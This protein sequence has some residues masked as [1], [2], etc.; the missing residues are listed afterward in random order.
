MGSRARCA[1]APVAGG[2]VAV[3]DG[4]TAQKVDA[5][6][7]TKHTPRKKRVPDAPIVRVS[8]FRSAR[9]CSTRDDCLHAVC[10]ELSDNPPGCPPARPAGPDRLGVPETGFP[11]NPGASEHLC[12]RT[13]RNRRPHAACGGR[14]RTKAASR[15]ANPGSG[16]ASQRNPGAPTETRSA[17]GTDAAGGTARPMAGSPWSPEKQIP[18]TERD[19]PIGGG[20]ADVTFLEAVMGNYR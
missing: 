16:G 6:R 2:G 20:H 15:R 5:P 12:R 13:V 18:V 1:T 10:P 8:A 11:W 7:T 3:L 14:Q 9:G 17:A 4:V 19:H